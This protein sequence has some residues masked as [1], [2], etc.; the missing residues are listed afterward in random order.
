MRIDRQTN[1]RTDEQTEMTKL[2]VAFRKFANAT[3]TPLAKM[4]CSVMQHSDIS[5]NVFNFIF[6]IN[7]IKYE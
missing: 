5:N 4:A 6:L 1:E 7:I 3:L 2:K